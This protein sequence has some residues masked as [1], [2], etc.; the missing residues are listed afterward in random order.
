MQISVPQPREL[1][2]LAMR[3]DIVAVGGLSRVT[4]VDPRKRDPR[5]FI[6]ELCSPDMSQGI[7]SV[8]ISN[9][10]L[11]FGTGRGKICFYDL[12]AEKFLPTTADPWDGPGVMPEPFAGTLVP[13]S[14]HP[15][16][17]QTIQRLP[18]VR[19]FDA[20]SDDGTEDDEDMASPSLVTPTQYLEV[21]GGWLQE[22]DSFWEYFAGQRVRHACYTHA[23]DPSGTRLF[24]GGGPL[25][26]G[27]T[28]GYMGLW[29]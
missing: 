9:N 21:G 17:M 14:R 29:E 1:V 16:M 23:W 20:V 27:L 2:A 6:G 25:A 18:A 5:A 4:L 8:C 13:G 26:F 3:H 15:M 12:R 24:A 11:S 10:L 22:N 19:A 28:G 7:R